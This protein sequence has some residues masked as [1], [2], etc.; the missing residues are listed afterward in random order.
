MDSGIIERNV[1]IHLTGYV[2]P[3]YDHDSGI[4]NGIAVKELG[5]ILEWWLSYY[6]NNS[7]VIKLPTLYSS[8]YNLKLNK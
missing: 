5:P 2:K 8:L 6:D 1:P 3:I 4:E 7:K